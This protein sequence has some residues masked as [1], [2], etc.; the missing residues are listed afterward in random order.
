VKNWLHE[1]L[2]GYPPDYV[3]P[4]SGPSRLAVDRVRKYRVSQIS[5]DMCRGLIG[6]AEDYVIDGPGWN[7]KDYECTPTCERDGYRGD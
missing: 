5:Y 3:G 6:V 7:G 1:A 4:P 2:Y